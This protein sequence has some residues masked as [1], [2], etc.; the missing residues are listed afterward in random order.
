MAACHGAPVGIGVFQ[1]EGLVR[2]PLAG[3]VRD[4]AKP[5]EPRG[6]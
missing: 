1:C 5:Y 3:P 4:F 6:A 2:G